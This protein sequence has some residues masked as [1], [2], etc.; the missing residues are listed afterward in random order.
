MDRPGSDS[1]AQL[2]FHEESSSVFPTEGGCA[3]RGWL[4]EGEGRD[5]SLVMVGTGHDWQQ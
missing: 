5:G 1:L 4:G 3:G 2:D